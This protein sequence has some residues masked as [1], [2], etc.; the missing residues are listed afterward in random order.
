MLVHG[1]NTKNLNKKP[2]NFASSRRDC[3]EPVL[4]KSSTSQPPNSSL[5]ENIPNNV[6][7]TLIVTN[8]TSTQMAV[9]NRSPLDSK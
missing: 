6:S 7:E 9:L 3:K 5:P 2:T 4:P 8:G 1:I